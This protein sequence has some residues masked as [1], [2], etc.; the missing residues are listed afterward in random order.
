[1]C[2]FLYLWNL[3]RGGSD[4][5]SFLSQEE[6]AAIVGLSRVQVARV[7]GRLRQ[8]GLLTTGRHW[9]RVMDMDR[10]RRECAELTREG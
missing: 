1:M 4:P 8:E 6:V 10:L 2:N 3:N 5:R 9:F 7:F